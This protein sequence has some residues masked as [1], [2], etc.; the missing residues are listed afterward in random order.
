MIVETVKIDD[1]ISPDYNPRHITPEALE[2]L[3][4][5][6]DEFGYI[7]PLIVNRV[8]MHVVGGNQRLECLKALDYKE[9]EVIFINEPDIN[10]E[11]A[12]NIRLNNSSGD[13]DIG[14]LDN[15]FNDLELEGFDLTLTG[16]ATE[17]LQPFETETTSEIPTSETITSDL[18]TGLKPLPTGQ[19][20][21]TS[22]YVEPEH[23]ITEDN[24]QQSDIRVHVS[25]GDL[26]KLGNHYLFCGDATNKDDL[27]ILL[28]PER[29]RA[30]IDL[31]FTD[32]PYGMKKEKDGVMNDNLNYNDLLEFN[33]RWI[34]L[35]FQALKSNGSWYC[36]GTDEPLMDIY[37]NI[38]KPMIRNKEIAFRN[39]L[40]WDKGNGQGQLSSEFRMYPVADE[41]CLFVMCGSESCQGF[42][43]NAEDYSENMDTIRLYL[44]QECEKC[45]W[46]GKDLKRIAG[47]SLKSGNHWLDKSQFALPTREVYESWQKEAIKQDYDAFKQDYDEL[48][49]DFYKNRSYFNNTH[50]NQNNVWHFKRTSNTEKEM[51]GGH[52]TPKPIALCTRAIL[53]SSRQG[54]NIL[55]VFGGSGSTLIACEETDRNCYMMELD[56]YYCQVII[57]RW[58]HYTGQKAVKIN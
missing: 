53:S 28:T 10:R 11:K 23:E 29:E 48:K 41:K 52:A 57:N 24:Y 5:S 1:L 31:V 30:V 17:N 54:E 3:K 20:E 32:P 37:S 22:E 18:N 19:P 16:F 58:E 33:K 40:T 47:H 26:Y 49:Q 7:D 25:R 4:Q 56:P 44:V 2:S 51:T 36:W 55:D 15:I 43:V 50:T 46:T 21:T 34:P 42:T 35:T 13:W 6:I 12:I 9:V 39:L 14:K 27:E 45:N 8:N 38:L